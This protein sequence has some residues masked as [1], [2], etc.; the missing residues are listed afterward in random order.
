MTS[1]TT[2][3]NTV[4]TTGSQP[5]AT[6]LG[7]DCSEDAD[8]DGELICV[9]AESDSL[10]AGGPANGF[11][12]LPCESSCQEDFG[13]TAICI[14][15]GMGG[16]YCMPMCVLGD[17]LHDCAG[18]ED[19][20]CDVIPARTGASCSGPADCPAPEVC[21]GGECL[22]PLEVCLPKCRADSDC[23]EGRFCD[24]GVGECVDEEPEGLGVGE[25]C[26]PDAA[27]DECLGFCD[28]SSDADPPEPRCTE[29]CVFDTY[30]ACG[31]ED[32]NAGTAACL[33]SYWGI[34]PDRGDLGTC[35]ALCD[36]TSDCPEG[37][38]CISFSSQ[39]LDPQWGRDG[40]CDVELPNDEVLD[41]E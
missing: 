7:E 26:D 19:V 10:I 5:V 9:T 24:P 38:G 22:F 3:A 30:P 21:A 28:T 17:G 16:Q 2:T 13:A 4:S 18:R 1:S 32:P 37:L 27:T 31:S 15:F 8:C 29:T 34:P 40:F 14:S 33:Q 39:N 11:C 23:P 25:P 35:F 6:G 20:A 12:T 36:C 41:C